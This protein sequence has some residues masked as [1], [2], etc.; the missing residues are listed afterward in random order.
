MTA[1]ADPGRTYRT[2][3]ALRG[4]AALMIVA[5]HAGSVFPADPFPESF[6]AVDLF[7]LLSGFVVANAYE[8]R[9]LAG[10][11]VVPFLRT[12]LIRLYPLYVFG[13]LLGAAGEVLIALLQGRAPDLVH[14]AEAALIGILMLPAVSPLPMGSSA[15]DGPTWTLLPELLINLVY[16]ALLRRLSTRTVLSVVAAGAVGLGVSER[17]YGTLD[18]G[19]WPATFP[20]VA[21]RLGFSFFLGV[22]FFR[23]RPERR[24][25]PWAAWSAPLV[26]TAALALHP[27]G[28]LHSLYELLLVLGLFPLV[29][30]WAVRHEPGARGARVFAWLGSSSYAI[31]VIH[32]PLGVIAG[33]L[34][35]A[36]GAQASWAVGALF[37]AAT[38]LLATALDAFYDRPLRRR[39][40]QGRR[41]AVT[42]SG[43][44][45]VSTAAA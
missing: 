29:T 11:G 30:W 21:A 2:L 5:R 3:D 34:L 4:V 24:R 13:L 8:A 17:V 41:G 39:L 22:A 23:L 12:R 10:C 38:A 33:V 9:L 20:M 45:P 25:A 36:L 28:R 16:A 6:L 19:W 43:A 1:A 35:S 44:A 14:L 27:A 32:Q 40:S 42:S 26:L 31:Y 37:V 7:F 18:G 15:L